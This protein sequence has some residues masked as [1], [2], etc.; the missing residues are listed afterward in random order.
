MLKA[1]RRK[2]HASDTDVAWAARSRLRTAHALTSLSLAAGQPVH[3]RAEHDAPKRTL[4]PALL[5]TASR[6]IIELTPTGTTTPQQL[7]RAQPRRLY[8]DTLDGT[9]TD[10]IGRTRLLTPKAGHGG[11]SG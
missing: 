11:P 8:R 6:L 10:V 4:P 9:T 2:K 1:K 3:D 7:G 5:D